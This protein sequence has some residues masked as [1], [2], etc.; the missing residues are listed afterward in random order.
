MQIL[1]IVF[2]CTCGW[3]PYNCLVKPIITHTERVKWFCV[4]FEF[5]ELGLRS[6]YNDSLRAEGS[7]VLNP[8]EAESF[9]LPVQTGPGTHP[10]SFTVGTGAFSLG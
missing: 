1:T 6:R 7:G 5:R 3:T 4:R 9:S 2:R 8:G 10:A